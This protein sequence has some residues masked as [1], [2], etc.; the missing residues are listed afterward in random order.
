MTP[1]SRR[2]VVWWAAALPLVSAELARA[3]SVNAKVTGL[4][5][6]VKQPSS[7][8][9]W[10]TA[11]TIMRSWKSNQSLTIE[12]ALGQIG[13]AYLSKFKSNQGLSGSDKPGFLLAAGLHAEPPQNY[14]A[15]GWSKLIQAHGPLWVTTNEGSQNRFSIHARV[16][17]SISGDGTAKGTNV[18][19]A[20][21]ADGQVHTE[22]LEV[23]AKKFE[24]VAI[25][26]L[27]QGSDLRQQVV[28]Y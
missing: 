25:I 1:I 13:A 3:D 11:A 28:R 27:G 12:T 14:S 4:I 9:C 6:A 8:T 15:D 22:S 26:D 21:P 20:D 18:V 10:A 19:V 7:M 17:T 24:D 23:F 2:R 16:L 5:A